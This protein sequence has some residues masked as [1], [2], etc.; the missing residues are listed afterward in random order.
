MTINRIFPCRVAAVAGALLLL[1]CEPREK[2][3]ERLE[4]KTAGLRLEILRLE[5]KDSSTMRAQLELENATEE[6]RKAL[7]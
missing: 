7:K 6:L 3:I 2:K 5:Q 1:A 4:S